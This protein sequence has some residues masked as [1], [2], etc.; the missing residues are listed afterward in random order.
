[1]TFPIENTA[2]HL[3]LTDKC[4]ASC[5][6]CPRNHY[7]GKERSHIENV[8]ISLEKFKQ[9]FPK[10]YLYNSV[11]YVYACGNNG[12]PLMAKD[13]LEIFTYLRESCKPETLLTINTNG[14]LRDKSWWTKLASVM[15]KHGVVVFA[16]DG[17]EGE[18]ELY[19]RGTYWNKII[20]NAKAFIAA[21]GRARSDTLIFK[22]NQERVLELEKYL[23]DIGFESVNLKPTNRFYGM[24]KF[25][26][27]N[28]KHETEYFL[29][30]TDDLRW[31]S[32]LPQPNYVRL[33]KMEEYKKMLSEVKVD[34]HC[35]K[36]HTLYINAYGKVYP[37]CWV[38]SLVENSD[39]ES[40]ATVEEQILRSRLALSAVRMMDE[41][42][43]I[44]LHEANTDILT[45]LKRVDW[46]S[47]ITKYFTTD[48]QMV[49]AKS[50]G[51]NILEVIK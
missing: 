16:I 19:R 5:P 21:G 49:C 51:T 38:G 44:N 11:N 47:K 18:H 10:E 42:G 14:S 28:K 27:Y 2:L 33:V 3:E 20:E 8:D 46:G 41:L 37:C 29:E 45:E 9:W 15:G 34:P 17:F 22:H 43:H 32:N 26:V 48:V 25:P 12:D 36:G 31:A 35:M 24:N 7:G 23:L 4:Q 40:V 39:I 50:C 30:P 13:C 1:M 6:M